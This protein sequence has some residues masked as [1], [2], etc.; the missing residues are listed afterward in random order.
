[1][2]DLDKL[3]Q[4]P[5][6]GITADQYV[7]VEEDLT[8]CFTFDGASNT[9]WRE[10]LRTTVL[11]EFGTAA[12]R[13]ALELDELSDEEEAITS[14]QTYDT[15]LTLAKDLQLFLVS[16]GKERAAEDQQRV[17]LSARIT[18]AKQS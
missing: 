13:P 18:H 9:N 11:S 17:I 1:M 7:T 14:N 16:K 4:E 6:C 12:K 3:V 5:C 10:N 8:T 2:S 15:A